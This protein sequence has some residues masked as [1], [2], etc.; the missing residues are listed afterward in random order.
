LRS[1]GD[2]GMLF[3]EKKLVK[4]SSDHFWMRLALYNGAQSCWKH[5]SFWHVQKQM[6]LQNLIDVKIL[7]YFDTGFYEK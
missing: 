5:V 4:L 1:G 7:F 2:A 6:I 3:G